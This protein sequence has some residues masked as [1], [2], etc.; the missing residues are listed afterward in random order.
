MSVHTE[1]AKRFLIP[2]V[3]IMVGTMWLLNVCHVLPDIDWV[4]TGGLG[5]LGILILAFGGVNK[6]TLVA[7]PWLL[8]A[9]LTSILRQ[10]DHLQINQEVPIL[11]LAFGILLLLVELLRLPLPEFMKEDQGKTDD[12]RDG[13]S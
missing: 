12:K 3:I 2:V 4:W 8:G 5:G 7:G 10:T 6:L 11:T 13:D 9:S 1:R